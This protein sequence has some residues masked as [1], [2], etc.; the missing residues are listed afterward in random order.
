M[1][2]NSIY[3]I[4]Y[5]HLKEKRNI[6]FSIIIVLLIIVLYITSTIINFA[7]Q[8]QNNINKKSLNART[9]IVERGSKTDE[10]LNQISNINH[11]VLN[12]SDKYRAQFPV[13]AEE[14]DEKDIKGNIVFNPLLI[15]NGIKII[16]GRT[17]ESDYEILI[18]EEF[19]PH[20]DFNDYG[21]EVI[22]LDKII[23]GKDLIGK[24]IKVYSEREHPVKSINQSW[25]EYDELYNKWIET[26]TPI[27]LT[28]VGTYDS[29]VNLLEK[30]TCFMSLKMF[31]NVKSDINGGTASC[32]QDNICT[33]EWFK[34]VDRMIVVD[35]YKNLDYVKNELNNMNFSYYP[36][37]NF[38]M[39][40]FKMLVSIPMC[41]G[42]IISIISITLIKNFIAKKLYNKRKEIGL[43]KTLGFDNN[44]I[45]NIYSKE[46]NIILST[47]FI[48]GF[49][50][51]MII[52]KTI[53]YYIYVAAELEYYSM[54]IEIP[55]IYILLLIAL[56]L[57]LSN[58]ILKKKIIKYLSYNVSDLI[59]DS[60]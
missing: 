54:N 5:K 18:P 25:S 35:E 33:E 14:F 11:V 48:I 24:S 47:C 15:N 27:S 8:Y 40:T 22:Y 10:E 57:L 46:N 42:L 43:L 17:I 53:K 58:Y 1:K 55:F 26:R 6:I 51:Y 9:L 28:I 19:Y 37:L 52:V 16:N 56:L 30:N 38:D 20:V 59:G 21:E 36:V 23:K 32:T 2:G 34:Y 7:L 44:Q 4:S 49:I 39:G 29:S 45:I 3:E 60:L 12:V 13:S 41:V 50:I 31:D